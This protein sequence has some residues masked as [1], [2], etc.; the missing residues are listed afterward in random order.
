M[1]GSVEKTR[2]IRAMSPEDEEHDGDRKINERPG[3]DEFPAREETDDDR[4]RDR[5]DDGGERN[6]AAD[7]KNDEPDKEH[8]RNGERHE[9]H[10]RSRGSRHAFAAFEPQPGREDMAEHGAKRCPGH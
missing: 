3:V 7:L 8:E 2:K 5:G 1:F 6:V 10:H 4:Q 9:S